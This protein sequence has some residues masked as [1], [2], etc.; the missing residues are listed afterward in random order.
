VRAFGAL[1]EEEADVLGN[2]AQDGRL[3]CAL[4]V[5]D[6]LDADVQV[7]DEE[8]EADADDEAAL[9][10]FLS[11]DGDEDAEEIEDEDALTIAAE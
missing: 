9:P 1:L 3:E 6:G 11:E 4:D 8:R 2:N 5:V 7:F 10:A